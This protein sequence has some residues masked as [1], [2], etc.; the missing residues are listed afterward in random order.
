MFAHFS[1][2]QY[3]YGTSGEPSVTWLP[4]TRINMSSGPSTFVRPSTTF[5]IPSSTHLTPP[6]IFGRTCYTAGRLS[7]PLKPRWYSIRPIQIFLSEHPKLPG[8]FLVKES[9]G[10]HFLHRTTPLA[11][12]PLSQILLVL[13]LPS[14]C[15]FGSA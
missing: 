15:I 10:E 5:L 6:P 4:G 1:P 12:A 9:L 11:V 3:R 14:G 2:V 13:P 8:D 7:P